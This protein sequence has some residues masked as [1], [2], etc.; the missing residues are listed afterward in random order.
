MEAKSR[1]HYAFLVFHS[2]AFL[3]VFRD[4]T[5]TKWLDVVYFRLCKYFFFVRFSIYKK[6][7]RYVFKKDKILFK[8]T[9]ILG[10]KLVSVF[11]VY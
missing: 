11:H 10:R 2:S 4:V 6:K 3:S 9:F 1:S 5:N 8:M 7:L